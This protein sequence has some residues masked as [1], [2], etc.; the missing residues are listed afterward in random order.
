MPSTAQ[1]VSDK[2]EEVFSAYTTGKGPLPL[3][4]ETLLENEGQRTKH[5][6]ETWKKAMKRQFTRSL[7]VHAHSHVEESKREDRT[8]HSASTRPAT[9]EMGS[10]LCWRLYGNGLSCT[11]NCAGNRCYLT[12][13]INRLFNPEITPIGTYPIGTPQTI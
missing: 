3:I 7:Q 11:A 9:A 4:Y 6:K 12:K 1:N 5:T 10:G 2:L 13:A 8:W